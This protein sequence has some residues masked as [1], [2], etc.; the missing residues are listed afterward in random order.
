MGI[1]GGTFDPVHLAHLR[2]AR[3]ALEACGLAQVRFIPSAR[4]PHRGEPGAAAHHRLRMVELALQGE[5]AFVADARE[6][7][8]EGPSFTVDT[9]A[10]LRAELGPRCPLCL[11]L[12]ADAFAL[13]ETWKHWRELLDAVHLVVAHR[14]G[15]PLE[16]ATPA[17]AHEFARRRQDPGTLRLSPA[18]GIAALALEP[19]DLSAS[20][21]RARL[22]AGDRPVHLLPAPVLAYIESNHLYRRLDAG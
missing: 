19:L 18:G 21:V 7:R 10:A 14:P 2:L 5:P 15:H 8:R 6:L 20:A 17:L 9:V 11:L 12:G 3:G 4:P 13:F 16:P 1:L 22:A